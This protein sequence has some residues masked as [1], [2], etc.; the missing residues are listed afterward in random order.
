MNPLFLQMQTKRAFRMGLL[1]CCVVLLAYLKHQNNSSFGVL[2]QGWKSQHPTILP[3]EQPA[4]DPSL[5]GNVYMPSVCLYMCKKHTLP[6]LFSLA[7]STYVATST[8]LQ[9]QGVKL[10]LLQL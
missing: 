1:L 6:P 2:I 8:M 7:Q 9:L 4:S 3:Q 5:C 10:F